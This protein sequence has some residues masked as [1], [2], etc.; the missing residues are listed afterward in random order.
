[1]SKKS[2]IERAKK[3]NQLVKS[4]SFRRNINM[5]LSPIDCLFHSRI[6]VR[7]SN[8]LRVRRRC[9]ISGRSR[10]VFSFFGISRIFLRD[11]AS[12]NL[13]PGFY[14]VSW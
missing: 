3:R 2:V 7:N 11:F 8:P 6:L 4:G 10:G 1:M 9:Y 5:Y 13:I 12:N 14:K